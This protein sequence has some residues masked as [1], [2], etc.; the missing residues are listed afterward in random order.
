MLIGSSV[1]ACCILA[2]YGS[3]N[4]HEGLLTMDSHQKGC[5]CINFA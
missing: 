3:A 2:V 4:D 1:L 5:G